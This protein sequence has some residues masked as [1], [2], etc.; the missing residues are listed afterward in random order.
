MKRNFLIAIAILLIGSFGCSD[1]SSI[2][3]A[4][5]YEF[6]DL[7]TLPGYGWFNEEFDNY[8]VKIEKLQQ[9]TDNFN[10]SLHKVVIFS[11]PSCSCPNLP[12]KRFP[13]IY[14]ILQAAGVPNSNIEL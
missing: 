5:K 4:V 13:A 11:R 6:G 14:K 7:Q 12:Y 1:D 8:E 10:P 3:S 9:I 2:P